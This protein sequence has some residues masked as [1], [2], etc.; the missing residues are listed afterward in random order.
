MS[1]FSS[2]G[3]FQVVQG[4]NLPTDSGIFTQL[5]NTFYTF[6]NGNYN[7]KQLQ[8]MF[9]YHDLLYI[10]VYNPLDPHSVSLVKVKVLHIDRAV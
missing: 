10:M 7:F 8:A 9:T 6:L 5:I 1:F 3:T 2:D 4:T